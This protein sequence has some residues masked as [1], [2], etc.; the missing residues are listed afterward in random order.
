MD[1]KPIAVIVDD[2]KPFLM[3]LSILLNRMNLEVLPVNNAAEAL[4]IARVTRPHLITMDMMMPEM[5]GLKP[6]V[7]SVL[8][9]CSLTCRSS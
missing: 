2:S 5:D 3:Y 9:R 1:A 7:Q 4:E 8:I 6:F